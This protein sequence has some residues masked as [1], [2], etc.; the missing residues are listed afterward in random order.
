MKLGLFLLASAMTVSIIGCSATGGTTGG[1]LRFDP[2]EQPLDAS[3]EEEDAGSG[4]GFSDLY[5]DFFGPTGRAS[6][7]GNG[8]CH[9][10]ASELGASSSAFICSDQATCYSTMTGAA[11]LAKPSDA[12][13]PTKSVL[14]GVLRH[15]DASNDIV[16]FMPKSPAYVFSSTSIA[17]I[18]TWIA[19][20]VPND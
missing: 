8:Q 9:G 13:D 1:D 12:S 10:S 11:N 5:R 19:A 14:L 2:T 15:R 20:G 4:T 7:A 18:S 6:C 3:S 16:G 17:R